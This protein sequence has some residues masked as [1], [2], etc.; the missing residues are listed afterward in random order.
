MRV[1]HEYFPSIHQLINTLAD[2]RNNSVMRDEDSSESGSD[3]FTGTSS[4][5]EAIKLL[6]CGYTDILDKLSL[7][8]K[9]TSKFLEN[10]DFSKSH[11]VEDVQGITPVIPNYLQGLPKTMCYRSTVPRKV[12]TI[13]IIYSPNENSS[14]SSDEF[15]DAGVVL[16]S[17]IRAIEKSSISI[18]LDCMF[19]DAIKNNEAVVGIV[20]IKDYKDRLDLQKLCFPIAH[21]SM[22]R[23][24]GFKYLE[25]APD[26]KESGFSFGYGQTPDL[27]KIEEFLKVPDNTVVLNMRLI[28]SLDKDPK[29]LMDYINKKI[30]SK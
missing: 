18:K 8:I 7:G 24:V 19:S 16:L 30:T 27:E 28:N 15:I 25:T 1:V 6:T 3:D 23:R 9:K 12:K 22:L 17:V 21:P 2:R 5:D 11:I 14:H 4:Y 10:T 26:M 13:N 29:K 20:K